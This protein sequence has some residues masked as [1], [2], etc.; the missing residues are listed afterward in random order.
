[1]SH[2]GGCWSRKRERRRPPVTRAV[3]RDGTGRG[4]PGRLAL[5]LPRRSRPAGRCVPGA[6]RT[7]ALPAPGR[8]RPGETRPGRGRRRR[9][10]PRG[11]LS[12]PPPPLRGAPGA[13]VAARGARSCRWRSV[14]SLALPGGRRCPARFCAGRTGCGARR[15]AVPVA[16]VGGGARLPGPL[17]CVSGEVAGLPAS[18]GGEAGSSVTGPPPP[19]E[20]G[21]GRAGLGL[22]KRESSAPVRVG[23]GAPRA[24]TGHKP[25]GQKGASGRR[26]VQEGR[27]NRIGEESCA[28]GL[29]LST[30]GF[31]DS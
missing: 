1:M 23:G 2:D 3:G 4:F 10:D 30:E 31:S 17:P 16:A 28:W 18:S 20:A 14:P 7:R 22:G 29:A 15:G 27:G 12:R 19:G 11:R 26:R 25:T 9:D 5:P 24:R 21:E 6:A 13:T 8:Y